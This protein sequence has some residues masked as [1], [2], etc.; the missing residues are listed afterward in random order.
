MWNREPCHICDSC[1]IGQIKKKKF[2]GMDIS[3]FHNQVQVKELYKYEL[4]LHTG[5]ITCMVSKHEIM[6]HNLILLKMSKQ[7]K[8]I[9]HAQH[10]V[11]IKQ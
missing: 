11:V 7:T 10:E 2:R 3:L 4:F 9:N 6:S 5:K 8:K 1:Q